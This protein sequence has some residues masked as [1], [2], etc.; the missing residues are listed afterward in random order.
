MR[1]K[2]VVLMIMD[3]WGVAVPSGA[4]A[5]SLAKKPNFDLW[6]NTY[7]AMVL[8]AA[9][10]AVG[11]SWGEMGNSEVGHLSLGA[12]KIIYQNLPRITRSISDGSYFRNQAFLKA[13]NQAKEKKGALHIMGLLSPGG[14]HSY[15]EHLY[16]L[17]ELAKNQKVDNV[18]IHVFLDGRDT[19]Y[20]SGTRFVKELQK[21]FKQIGTGNIAS[22]S[23]R[24][25]GPPARVWTMP[26]S[27]SA[28]I[29]SSTML[30]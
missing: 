8:Q 9:G 1:P 20:N 17:I 2:P 23:G 27:F 30:R 22:I 14:I 13:V 7:P 24:S 15:N 3:G 16:A 4:N 6:L 29:A 11:L 5:I 18:F 19:E 28:A 21:K 26:I 12:G 25:G 10:E